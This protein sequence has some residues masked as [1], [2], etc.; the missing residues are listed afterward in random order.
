MYSIDKFIPAPA[1]ILTL[2]FLLVGSYPAFAQNCPQ[3]NLNVAEVYFFDMEGTPFSEDMEFDPGTVVDGQI[4]VQFGGSANN[5]YSL[6]FA[7]D[8]IV[9][10]VVLERT[11]LCLFQGSNVIKDKPQFITN[12]SLTWGDK[13]EFG[14][15]FMRWYTN[16]SPDCPGLTGGAAQCYAN[17]GTF[18]VN[19]PIIPLPVI[20]ENFTLRKSLDDQSLIVLWSTSRE[21][22]SSHFE[23]ERSVGDINQ[24]KVIAE[25]SS[26]G[27]SEQVTHYSYTDPKL[28][29]FGTRLYYRI[30]QVDLDGS[31]AFSPTMMAESAQSTVSN[32]YWNAYPNPV[33]NN[34]LKLRFTGKKSED[35]VQ[36]RIYSMS[37]HFSASFREPGNYIDLSQAIKN[38]PKGVIIVEITTKDHVESIKV[39]KK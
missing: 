19:T 7:Y 34:E 25:V 31:H 3:N 16:P 26:V 13:V 9:N 29:G 35:V 14:N 33:S 21:W 39:V 17:P 38:F 4:F 6:F 30:K 28:P 27:W 12:F 8:L 2:C 36:V 32:T 15:I 23:I 22:D 1:R 20:W 18:R 10:D 11:E 5:A 37:A 24:F